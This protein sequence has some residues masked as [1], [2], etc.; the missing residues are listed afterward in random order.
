M[1]AECLS[2]VLQNPEEPLRRGFVETGYDEMIHLQK[3]PFVSMCSHHF[4]FFHGFIHF[5]YL[6]DKRIVGLSKIPR[7]IEVFAK[8]PQVQERFT[9]EI[10]DCFQKV[11]KPRGCGAVVTATHLCMAARGI[12]KEGIVV[13]TTALAGVFKKPSVKGEFLHGS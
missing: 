7:M 1:F 3:I 11:V 12:M 6:P 13:K 2:G 9:R 8:R 4:V 5:A 10:V